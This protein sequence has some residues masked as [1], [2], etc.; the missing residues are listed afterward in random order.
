MT[1]KERLDIYLRDQNVPY[2]LQH[3]PLAYTA[4]SVA[5]SEH[6]S[7]RLVAKTVMVMADQK[8][9]MLVLPAPER[10]DLARVRAALRAKEVRIAEEKEFSV[11][12]PDCEVGAM[13]PFGNLYGLPVLVDHDLTAYDTIVFRAGTHT[14]TISLP[15]REF[16]RLVQPTIADLGSIEREAR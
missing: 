1:C 5:E 15:Y 12:F 11:L 3:H 16:E 9:R 7:G 10:V 14:D 6:I 8:M 2:R 13:P 4:Q